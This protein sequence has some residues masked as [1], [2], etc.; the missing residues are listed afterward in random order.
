MF[1]IFRRHFLRIKAISKKK[2]IISICKYI[3]I[4]SIREHFV[5]NEICGKK[6][7][8]T[9]AGL[10]IEQFFNLNGYY[11]ILNEIHFD[12]KWK[13][14]VK[15]SCASKCENYSEIRTGGTNIVCNVFKMPVLIFEYSIFECFNF[16]V[17][18]IVQKRIVAIL[19]KLCKVYFILVYSFKML[20]I[21]KLWQTFQ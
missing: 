21:P 20:S 7:D 19:A 18:S 13:K 14:R 15:L 3:R 11:V 9:C 10:H 6:I 17:S 2:T 16:W 12:V 5:L 1:F 8:N 4:T